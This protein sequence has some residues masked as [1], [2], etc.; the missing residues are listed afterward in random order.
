MKKLH[1]TLTAALLSLCASCALLASPVAAVSQATEE[2]VYAAL[3]EIGMPPTF[4]Q[5]TFNHAHK[6]GAV[7]DEDGMEINGLYNTFDGWVKLIREEGQDGIWEAYAIFSGVTVEELK[8]RYAE[9]EANPDAPGYVPSVEPE[10][11][12]AEMTLEEK[13]AYLDSLPEEERAAF[14]VNLT[15]EERSSLIRQLEPEQKQEIA[16][17]L[18]E[19]G[20]EMGMNLSVEDV[21][22][23][24]FQLRDKD[25]RLID[26]AGLGLTV[27]PTGWDT[28]IPVLGGSA[29]ILLALGG[30]GVMLRRTGKQEDNP[31]G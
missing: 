8:A 24:R 23:F 10:K 31:N 5:E 1:H 13:R 27:D 17:N 6:P 9:K 30:I 16:G 14:L 28:T 22:S 25:G 19:L 3:E 12:F 7:R 11:P 15:P 26:S 21:D 29:M 20:Q 2:D 18:I 4:I